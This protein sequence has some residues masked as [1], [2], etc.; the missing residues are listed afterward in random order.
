MGSMQLSDKMSITSVSWVGSGI[1][2]WLVMKEDLSLVEED[3]DLK[4]K[5]SGAR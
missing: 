5:L 4:M 2:W 3:E 1:L